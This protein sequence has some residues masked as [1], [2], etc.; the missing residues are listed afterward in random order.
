MTAGCSSC[1]TPSH[2]AR[3]AVWIA[4]ADDSPPIRLGDGV[5][6]G[7]SP[8]GA[9]VLASQQ[10]KLLALP[11][12]AGAPRPVSE[13]F[14]EAIR[15]ASWFR[16]GRRVLVWGQAKGGKTG[17]FVVE[18]EGHEPR[19]V[20]PEGYELVSAGNALSPDGLRVVARSPEN[21][22]A[23]CPVDGGPARPIPGLVGLFV[24][25]QWA[26]DGKSFFVFRLG[27]IP[28]RVEKVDVESGRRTLWKELAPPDTAGVAVRAIA[29]TPDEKYYAY[30]CQ[31]YLTT[32]YLVENLESWRRPTFWSRL[33]GGR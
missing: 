11:T 28:A 5:A 9:W 18:S 21:Q 2:R 13:G 20:A 31:Q 7:L 4:R 17:I 23:L 10:G 29:M 32:L 27:E 26:A 14:F 1:E 6:H 22:I 25:V 19:R 8:D 3:Q 15:W 16:D 30:S 24:P 33:F 12:A